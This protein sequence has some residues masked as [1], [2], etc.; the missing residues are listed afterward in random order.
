MYGVSKLAMNA[1]CKAKAKELESKRIPLNTCC[2]GMVIYSICEMSQKCPWS[3]VTHCHVIDLVVIAL[4]VWSS[5]TFAQ[6]PACR[7]LHCMLCTTSMADTIYVLPHS[8][9]GY[10]DT[11]MTSHRGPRP[12]YDGAKVFTWL[13]TRPPQECETGNMYVFDVSAGEKIEM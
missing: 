3:L 6:P 12:A 2:P 4:C 5:S 9:K 1:Y 10:C 11:D 13:A 7:S 8:L